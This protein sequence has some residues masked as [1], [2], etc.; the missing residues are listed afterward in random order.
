MY[1]LEIIVRYYHNKLKVFFFGL[2]NWLSYSHFC[3]HLLWWSFW[4]GL[5]FNIYLCFLKL[6]LKSTLWFMRHFANIQIADS[7]DCWQSFINKQRV[8]A[9]CVHWEWLSATTTHKFS[10]NSVKLNESSQCLCLPSLLTCP[11]NHEQGLL[12][13]LVSCMQHHYFLDLIKIEPEVHE[14]FLNTLLLFSKCL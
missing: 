1:V 4:I 9:H 10:S 8:S 6:P 13:S 14:I 2:L 5:I 12:Q 3:G 7:N 11:D